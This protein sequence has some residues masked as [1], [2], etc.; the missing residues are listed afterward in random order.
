MLYDTSQNIFGFKGYIIFSFLAPPLSFDVDSPLRYFDTA[1]IMN[2]MIFATLNILFHIVWKSANA[3]TW[4]LCLLHGQVNCKRWR[5]ISGVF[6]C[7]AATFPLFFLLPLSHTP[8]LLF[9]RG[10]VVVSRTLLRY[11]P[12]RD[13]CMFRGVLGDISIALCF[14]NTS[15]DVN[16]LV[17]CVT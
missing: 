14:E 13:T 17:S 9:R 7:S 15:V 2:G 10:D 3:E 6:K 4:L 5:K 1:A 12:V 16:C 8:R 11:I